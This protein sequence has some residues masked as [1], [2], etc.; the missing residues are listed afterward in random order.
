M[1][2][3][4]LLLCAVFA[5]IPLRAA[6]GYGKNGRASFNVQIPLKMPGTH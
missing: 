6:D 4:P 1:K 2:I 5:S 3:L